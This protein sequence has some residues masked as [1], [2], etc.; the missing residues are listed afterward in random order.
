[1]QKPLRNSMLPVAFCTFCYSTLLNT[2]TKIPTIQGNAPGP[3]VGAQGVFLS[4]FSENKL[5]A[6]SLLLDFLAQVDTMKALYD[7]EPRNP[8]HV[9][10]FDLIANDLPK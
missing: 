7:Q 9:P 1:M 3:F 8:A 6:T 2:V 5:V 10:T 4:A